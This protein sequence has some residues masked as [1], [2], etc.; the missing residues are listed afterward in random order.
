MYK[1]C[2]I[3]TCV[4]I[5]EAGTVTYVQTVLVIIITDLTITNLIPSFMDRTTL[6]SSALM[7]LYI[8]D[9]ISKQITYFIPCCQI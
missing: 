5:S 3:I 2:L 6:R 9:L 4:Y 1:L 7:M 8:V